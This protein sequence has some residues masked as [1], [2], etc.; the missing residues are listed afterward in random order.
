MCNITAGAAATVDNG[1]ATKES[2]SSEEEEEEQQ[3]R[4]QE[5]EQEKEKEQQLHPIQSGM[6]PWHSVFMATCMSAIFLP[7]LPSAEDLDAMSS[8]ETWT[9]R[10]FPDLVSLEALA[11]IRL[12]T[13]AVALGLTFYLACINEGWPVFAN[14]KPHS[15]LRRE[16]I[17]LRGIGT[18]C[19]FT[20]WCW[21]IFGLGFLSRGTI[22][23]AACLVEGSSSSSSS[24]H[25]LL[26]L[27]TE[28]VA[29]LEDHVLQ[30]KLLLR[31]T[32]VLWELTGP[33]AIL[34]S[35]VV[36]YAIW[37]QVLKGGKPHNLA[38]VRNQLQHNSN[39]IMS[40]A[41]VALLGGPPVA[42]SHLSM[43]IAIGSFYMVFTWCTGKWFFG[44]DKIGPQYIYWFMDTTLGTGTTIAMMVLLSVM[45]SSFALFAF[46]VSTVLGDS[47]SETAPSFWKNVLIL[48]AGTRLVC[49]FRT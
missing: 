4:E 19:P 44:N 34:V 41:E 31:A 10:K 20:S 11:A 16:F 36:K 35:S 23:L 26:L 17:K 22:A 39:S 40:L 32:L 8:V 13:A 48:V 25:V 14:Y 21:L 15:K 38:G 30:N 37:P 7:L 2:S 33:L 42:F 29:F 28:Q 3:Q 45:V 6:P 46:L 24:S 27:T 43:A 1:V 12:G 5:Q 18:L 47:A 9:H 49:R